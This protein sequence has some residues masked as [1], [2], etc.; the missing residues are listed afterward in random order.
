MFE[1]LFNFLMQTACALLLARFIQIIG[2]DTAAL[3]ALS[4]YT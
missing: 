3:F 1:Y 2:I 4:L